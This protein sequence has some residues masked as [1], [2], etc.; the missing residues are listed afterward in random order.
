[1]PI[2]QLKKRRVLSVFFVII[3][4]F[5]SSFGV[6]AKEI[7]TFTIKTKW[8]CITTDVVDR[9][10]ACRNFSNKVSSF[11]DGTVLIS[12]DTF[13]CINESANRHVT[14]DIAVNQTRRGKFVCKQDAYSLEISYLTNFRRNSK[15]IAYSISGK[16]KAN[17]GSAEAPVYQT[18][19]FTTHVQIDIFGSKCV[20]KRTYEFSE[21]LGSVPGGKGRYK[22]STPSCT[23]GK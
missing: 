14:Y 18:L 23:V 20:G 8:K 12:D 3:S 6:K 1:M 9:K 22:F 5:L 7:D 15:G 2:K 11:P 17:I 4:V 16:A 21:T 10:F 13:R 19:S